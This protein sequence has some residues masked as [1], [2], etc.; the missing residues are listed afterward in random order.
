[1]FNEDADED[2]E[3]ATTS[4]GVLQTL[5]QDRSD[6]ASLLLGFS[7]RKVTGTNHRP[8]RE[9]YFSTTLAK[10]TQILVR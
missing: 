3:K 9:T 7:L 4:S 2:A 5:R 1:M 10:K 8:A 6:N